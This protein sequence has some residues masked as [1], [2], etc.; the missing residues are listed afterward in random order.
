MATQQ[1]NARIK[2]TPG[3]AGKASGALKGSQIGGG[4]G[5]IIGGVAGG[6]A[7]AAGGPAGIAVGA[8]KGAAAGA[9]T[10]AGLGNLVGG[11][12]QPGQQGTAGTQE[13]AAQVPVHQISQQ[14]QQIVDGIRALNNL[15][16]AKSRYLQPLTSAYLKSQMEL[17]RRG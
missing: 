8:A 5:G 6:L 16:E 7:G 2:S 13:L 14:S 17:K 12:I 4:L 3:Q 15:P 10:G 1:I 9:S 11:A